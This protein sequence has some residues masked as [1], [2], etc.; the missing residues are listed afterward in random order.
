MKKIIFLML[1]L[2]TYASAQIYPT[3]IIDTV[4]FT[5]P[6]D[7]TIYTAGDIVSD[8]GSHYKYFTLTRI[9]NGRTNSHGKL[10]Y[11][12]VQMDTANATNTTVKVRFFAVSD[13]TGLY[14]ALPVD[15]AAFQSKFQMGAGYYRWFG[16]VAVTMT[17]FGTTA[18]G[19]TSS[20]GT[21]TANIPYELLNGNLY[22]I[23]L[24]T[25]AFEPGHNGKFRIIVNAD[26]QF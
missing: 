22:A 7:T 4:K 3:N 5:R 17:I 15:N 26:R 2:C 18:G 21:A 14:G 11:V 13:T 10:T 25:G 23:V 12:T 9:G 20:E 19:A 8:S 6:A 16:D 24:A 1:V